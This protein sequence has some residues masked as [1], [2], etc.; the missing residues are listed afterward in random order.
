MLS[1]TWE[2]NS[3]NSVMESNT[4]VGII[5]FLFVCFFILSGVP[6]FEK[7]KECISEK[8]SYMYVLSEICNN[9]RAVHS[10]EDLP[11]IFPHLAIRA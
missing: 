10:E 1:L 4:D 9:H 11:G 5:I 7:R 2:G 6:T 3:V 8:V